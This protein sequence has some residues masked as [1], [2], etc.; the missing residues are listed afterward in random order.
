VTNSRQHC[1]EGRDPS[2]LLAYVEGELDAAACHELESH[3]RTCSFCALE[4][5]SLRKADELL[6]GHHDAFH[7]SADDLYNFVATGEDIGQR[8]A[9]HLASCQDCSDDAELLREMLHVGSETQDRAPEMPNSLIYRLEQLHPLPTSPG[10]L[11]RLY[12]SVSE[13]MRL[14]FQMPVLALGTAAVV[15]VFVIISV[16]L[17]DTFKGIETPSVSVPEKP[18]TPERRKSDIADLERYGQTA[19]Q[20]AAVGSPETRANEGRVPEPAASPPPPE[21]KLSAA[22]ESD[23]LEKPKKARPEA[24]PFAAG[25]AAPEVPALKQGLDSTEVVPPSAP[26]MIQERESEKGR[27]APRMEYRKSD[28]VRMRQATKAKLSEAPRE[29]APA[30]TDLRSGLAD[31]RIPLSVTVT[32][33]EG[34]TIPWLKFTLPENLGSRYS[35]VP[36]VE[37]EKQASVGVAVP[38]EASKLAFQDKPL[39]ETRITIVVRERNGVFDLEAKLF[40]P[41]STT[42]SRKIDAVGVAKEELPERMTSGVLALLEL[43]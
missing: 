34:R 37:A 18:V 6:K 15:V 35:L 22:T 9:V 1:P 32:D 19:P 30:S 16:P 26:P 14:P 27:R 25:K 8:I 38:K 33:P 2:Q 13:W 39:G 41:G 42:A 10:V 7:P 36:E 4:C 17:W 11:G 28:D 5:E 3:L 21:S 23:K 24:R 12:S 31:S 20:N 43:R 40:E 29:A